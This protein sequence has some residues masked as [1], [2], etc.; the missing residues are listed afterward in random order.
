[1]AWTA[2]KNAPTASPSTVLDM[3]MDKTP[4]RR[5]V[6]VCTATVESIQP[7]K[8][9]FRP[10][11]S[12]AA[13][14]RGANTIS[15]TAA[16]DAK[17]DRVEVAFSCPMALIKAGA[18][19][20]DT[21]AKDNTHK[22]DENCNITS[23]GSAPSSFFAVS[24]DGE[25]GRSSSPNFSDREFS[26]A[27]DVVASTSSESCTGDLFAIVVSFFVAIGDRKFRTT[28][29]ILRPLTEHFK[30]RKMLK[31]ST[32]CFKAPIPPTINGLPRLIENE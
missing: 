2:T 6:R 27:I 4:G 25:T 22:S 26:T 1:M 30:R 23:D 31:N 19:D 17:Y 28:G 32:L 15:P 11:A 9:G 20:N 12:I 5:A 21:I 8:A 16:P 7:S 24:N 13:P 14:R 18:G 3:H 10:T 29:K